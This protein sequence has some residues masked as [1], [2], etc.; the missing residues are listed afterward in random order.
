MVHVRKAIVVTISSLL[1]YRGFKKD[2]PTGVLEKKK[3]LEIYNTFIQTGNAKFLVDQIFR[4]F[5]ADN[6]GCIDFKVCQVIV[7]LDRF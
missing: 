4:I 5:D 6:N 7:V 1:F 3:V 2:C